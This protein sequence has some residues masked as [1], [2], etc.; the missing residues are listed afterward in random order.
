MQSRMSPD[1][2][3]LAGAVGGSSGLPLFGRD[4]SDRKPGCSQDTFSCYY[5]TVCMLAGLRHT[6]IAQRHAS[7]PKKG[8]RQ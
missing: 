3:G 6:S 5:S 2:R 7:E 8:Q 1:R 4:G